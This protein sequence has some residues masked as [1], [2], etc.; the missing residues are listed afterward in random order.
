[1]TKSINQLLEVYGLFSSEWTIINSIKLHGE[2]TQS[3]L[4][5]YLNI[6]QAAISKSLGKLEKKGL[7]ERRTGEDKRE[8][9]V[10]LSK[11]ALQQYPEWSR[12]IA[13]HREEIL[14]SLQEDE[15]KGLTQLLN[16]IRQRV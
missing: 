7:I 10:F 6:E 9:Y 16:K 11:T 14:S 1:M 5:D 12:V 4:A 13:A 15:Q 8:K 3:A 2:M